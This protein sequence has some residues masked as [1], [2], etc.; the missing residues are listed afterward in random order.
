MK[1]MICPYSWD[2]GKKIDPKELSQF[3]YDF[4]QSA[5][6]KKMTFMIIHCPNCSREFKFDPIQWKAD[7]FGYSNPDYSKKK[8]KKTTKQLTAILNKAKIEIPA[9]YFEYLTSNEF[10]P[11]VSVFS[12][13][14]DFIL[15]DLHELCEKVKVDGKPYFTISQ[16]K[17]FTQTLLE[18]IG[19]DL[20]NIQ[21]LQ[22]KALAD[23]L[24]IGY[25]NTR[26]LYIDNSDHHSVR[27]FHPDGGDIEETGMVYDEII[28]RKKQVY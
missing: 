25:E 14:E 26:I 19:D 3:D 10:N 21:H 11:Q 20:P 15:Y 5:V 13:E 8:V 28:N 2:C 22:Y 1:E 7:E 23:Y 4:V 12:D 16:L 27:I 6:E 17:G 9:P 18:V 24:T